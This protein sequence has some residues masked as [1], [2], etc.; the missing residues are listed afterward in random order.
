MTTTT[1]MIGTCEAR[2]AHLSVEEEERHCDLIET[3]PH[4]VQVRGQILS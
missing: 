2:H 3:V 1:S 4:R